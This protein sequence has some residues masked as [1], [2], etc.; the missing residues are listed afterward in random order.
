M[1][2]TEFKREFRLVGMPIRQMSAYA[3]TS[4]TDSNINAANLA[5]VVIGQM[6]WDDH[7]SHTVDTTGSSAFG[8]QAGS[9]IHSNAGTT[10]KVGIASVDTSNGP[11]GRPV[12]VAGVITYD[13]ASVMA[14]GSSLVT[15]SSW[16]ES[17]PTA[18]SK[19]I[20][21]GELIAFCWQ[22]TSRAGSDAILIRSL[23]TAGV[24]SG[25]PN[26]C[27]YNG[28]SFSSQNL[29]PNCVVRA[30]NGTR[31]VIRGT[32]VI[33]TSSSKVWN[34]SSTP[35]EY[36]NI[37]QVPYP[38]K[39]IGPVVYGNFAGD[40]D[41]V[42][43]EDPLGTPVSRASFSLDGNTIGTSSL[44]IYDPIFT[45]GFGW[46]LTPN[47]PYYIAAKPGA[48]N[49]TL[50][51]ITFGN[52]AHQSTVPG[53]DNGYAASRNGGVVSA[54]NSQLD[55]FFIGLQVSGGDTGG[56]GSFSAG[57]IGC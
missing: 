39:A 2:I 28:S 18:G 1:A 4:L 40:C 6:E 46:Q 41:F 12:N 9:G 56:G 50:N 25:L 32:S 5:V 30:A 22:M 34:S 11:T 29:W 7:A 3:S 33:S 21:H 55:R 27:S 45:T 24:S 13:V 10:L 20:A 15:Q 53:G 36:G 51:Y 37:I 31:G 16:N 44:A 48:S 49:A 38:C 54:Q 35:K 47:V 43:Y 52:E 19:T 17:V 14:G 57:I 26:F 42:L 23:S 8:W